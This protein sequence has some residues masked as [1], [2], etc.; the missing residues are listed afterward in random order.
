MNVIG[1]LKKSSELYLKKGEEIQERIEKLNYQKKVADAQNDVETANKIQIELDINAEMV[2][3][4]TV[5]IKDLTQK[6]TTEQKVY[7]DRVDERNKKIESTDNL[8]KFT[9]GV[10]VL[11]F[12]GIF[13]GFGYGIVVFFLGLIIAIPMFMY[14]SKLKFANLDDLNRASGKSESMVTALRER[15]KAEINLESSVADLEN[16][17]NKIKTASTLEERHRA[18][19]ESKIALAKITRAQMSLTDANRSV[20]SESNK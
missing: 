1:E 17:A 4:L 12:F 19:A 14:N 6:I 15:L 8:I 9:I 2:K 5:E 13:V 11:S 18:E 20:D 3:S 7:K 16:S 10:S